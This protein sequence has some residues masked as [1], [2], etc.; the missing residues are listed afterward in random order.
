MFDLRLKTHRIDSDSS[1]YKVKMGG[2]MGE[3]GAAK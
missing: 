1:P 3:G 2:L